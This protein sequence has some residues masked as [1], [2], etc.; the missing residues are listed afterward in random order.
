[1]QLSLGVKWGKALGQR[2]LQ[3]QIGG[4]SQILPHELDAASV[5]PNRKSLRCGHK[6]RVMGRC[7]SAASMVVRLLSLYICASL[8]AT[9]SAGPADI[10]PPACNFTS[11]KDSGM[12]QARNNMNITRKC[13]LAVQVALLI[14]AGFM[15]LLDE[16]G[17]TLLCGFVEQAMAVYLCCRPLLCTPLTTPVLE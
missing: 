12:G 5:I 11:P 4:A 16:E 9:A 14:S 2:M 13:C 3:H 1:M 7:L 10:L 6:G 17:A 8:L 15:H